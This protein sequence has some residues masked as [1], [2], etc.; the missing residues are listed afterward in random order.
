MKLIK[1]DTG[2]EAAAGTTAFVVYSGHGGGAAA[3]LFNYTY[4]VT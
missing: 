3:Q 4:I 2:K 1:V